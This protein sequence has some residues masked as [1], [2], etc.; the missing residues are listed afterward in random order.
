[1]RL[2]RKKG[3]IIAGIA[4]IAAVAVLAVVLILATVGGPGPDV[5]ARVNGE[6]IMAEDVAAV[7]ARYLQ[8]GMNLT[9]VQ[10]LE[11]LIMEELVYQ[12]AKHEGHLLAMEEAEQELRAQL[13]AANLTLEDLQVQLDSYEISYEEYLEDFRRQLAIDDYVAAGVPVPEVTDEEATEYYEDYRESFLL[14]YPDQPF[15]P[16]EQVQSEIVKLLSQ[17]KQQEAMLLLIEDLKEKADIQI[18]L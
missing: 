16:F 7:Q 13:G 14:R 11:Q 9:P 4:G 6:K 17:E 10:A 1:M 18:Y 3:K 2:D 15:P 8:Y 5:A 12:E